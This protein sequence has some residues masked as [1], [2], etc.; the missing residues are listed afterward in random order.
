MRKTFTLKSG[1]NP[2]KKGFFQTV[3]KN[4][5]SKAKKLANVR[6]VGDFSK[7]VGWDKSVTKGE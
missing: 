3:K 2:D 4:L 6:S 1:N 5:K 7:A